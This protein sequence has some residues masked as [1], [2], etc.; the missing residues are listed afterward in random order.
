MRFLFVLLLLLGCVPAEAPAPVP[1]PSPGVPLRLASWNVHNFFDEVDDPYGD[2]RPSEVEVERK[3]A[4]M[5]EVLNSVEAEIVALQEVENR[6]LL[7]RFASRLGPGWNVVLEEGND[8]ARGI[9]VALLSRLPVADVESHRDEV[10][11]SVA[12]A[13]PGYRFSRDCLEVHLGGRFPLVVLVNHFKSKRDGGRR[14]DAKRRAQALGA[15]RIVERLEEA[16]PGVR[17]ALV[18]DLNDGPDSWTL[19]PLKA[20]LLD[21]FAAVPLEERW[22]ARYGG[23]GVSI[24]HIFVNQA[25]ARYVVPGSQRVWRAAREVSDHAAV[26]VDLKS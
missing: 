13:P 17:L 15:A 10:L 22:T 3:M 19:E 1:A 20:Q 12:G 26:S 14:S 9:D 16:Q 21:V 4:A 11:P 2:E 8:T 7:E 25:L 18:G 23:L 5:A 24:D 6:P